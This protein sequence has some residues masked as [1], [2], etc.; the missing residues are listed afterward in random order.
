MKKIKIL[1]LLILM[2]GLIAGTTWAQKITS[3]KICNPKTAGISIVYSQSVPPSIPVNIS[4]K[5]S[6]QLMLQKQLS[7]KSA[8]L[9]TASLET[10]L[11]FLT[12]DS[13]A[14]TFTCK[15]IIR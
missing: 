6:G 11:Y 2:I 13:E 3:H 8:R 7:G 1:P 12:V 14:G 9:N 5:Q 15:L 10:G 4:S